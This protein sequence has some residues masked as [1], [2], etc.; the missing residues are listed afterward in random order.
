MLQR[1]VHQDNF[2]CFLFQANR[3][4]IEPDPASATVRFNAGFLTQAFEF[5]VKFDF[6]RLSLPATE[7]QRYT[8]EIAM[9]TTIDRK[10]RTEIRRDGL[11]CSFL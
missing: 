2:A 9:I 5:A 3:D 8:H 1:L 11:R 10:P 6:R 4:L 7:S